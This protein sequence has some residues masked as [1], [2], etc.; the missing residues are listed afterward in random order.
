MGTELQK[1]VITVIGVDRVGIVA[2]ISS[3]LAESGANIIDIS[4]TIMGDLF[5]MVMMIDISKASVEFKALK[6]RLEQE[7][8]RLGV[9]VKAQHE[10]IFR[11]MHR[12]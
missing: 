6:E 10:Q 7:G 9:E 1:V 12:V 2:S 5:A 3:I 4:Q 8:S 11:Y